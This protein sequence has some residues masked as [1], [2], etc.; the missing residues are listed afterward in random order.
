MR[1]LSGG[2]L[3]GSC[4]SFWLPESQSFWLLPGGSPTGKRGDETGEFGRMERAGP[5]RENEAMRKNGMM[6]ASRW[7]AEKLAA[8]FDPH[9][10][11]G[12]P[13]L[14]FVCRVSWEGEK[15]GDV[16]RFR[17]YDEEIFQKGCWDQQN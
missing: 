10:R 4:Q 8:S 7:R 6:R 9:E 5:A 11:A 13:T 14:G 17:N 16:E 15:D 3:S 2:S 1:S 12:G